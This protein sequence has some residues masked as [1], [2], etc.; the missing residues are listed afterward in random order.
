M[1]H[2]PMLPDD[3]NVDHLGLTEATH[4]QDFVAV[5]GAHLRFD[6]TRNAW[7]RFDP[8]IHRWV[9]DTLGM[10]WI[11]L[12]QFAQQLQADAGQIPDEKTRE[13][14]QKFY[15]FLQSAPGIRHVISIV[16]NLPPVSLVGDEW[17]QDPWLLGTPSGIVDLRTGQL[18]PARP[19]DLITQTTGV[20]YGPS[21]DCPRWLQFLREIFADADDLVHYICLACGYTLTGVTTEQ[22]LWI[23]YGTGANG[24]STFLAVLAHVLGTYAQ[25]IP[26]TSIE[27]PQR[28]AVPDDIAAIR[29]KRFV[30]ASETIEGARLNVARVKALVGGDLIAARHLYGRWFQFRPMLK[31][32]TSANH[33]PQVEDDSHGF[34]RRVHL[35]PF[36]VQF[37]GG[38]RDPDLYDKLIAESPAILRWA[39]EGCLAWQAQGCLPPPPAVR[40]AT[41]QFQDESDPLTDFILERCEQDPLA[42]CGAT[43]L[44][45]AYASWASDRGLSPSERLTATKF[46][47]RMGMRFAKEHTRTG[48]IYRGVRIRRTQFASLLPPGSA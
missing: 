10:I 35:V 24:K 18:R 23:L 16:Q 11:L 14:V 13:K 44:F 3:S 29:G 36:T 1:A 42:S 9:L 40:Q 28:S 30:M 45:S 39:V 12:I 27:L 26:F 15:K 4:A 7:Y 22:V 17:D 6:H 33:R 20:P 38:A 41:A 46:G 43:Q 37:T 8:D 21:S 5:H 34:W 47:T 25:T 2:D 32:W 19:E 48:R 31:L